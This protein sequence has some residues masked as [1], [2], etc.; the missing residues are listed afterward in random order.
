M[1]R[2]D[3]L[4]GNSERGQGA[5]IT[6]VYWGLLGALTAFA[7]WGAREAEGSGNS[8][9]GHGATILRVIKGY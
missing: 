5:S 2:G 8:E 7:Y 9:G 6:G 3:F 4:N 1:L